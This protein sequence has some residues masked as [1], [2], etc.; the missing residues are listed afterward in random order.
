MERIDGGF[1]I[2]FSFIF[3]ISFTLSINNPNC[4]PLISV[5]K[6]C[7][8]SVFSKLNFSPRSIIEIIFP[9]TLINP[10]IKLGEFGIFVISGFSIISLVLWISIAYSSSAKLKTTNCFSF[11]DDSSLFI[12]VISEFISKDSLEELSLDILSSEFILTDEF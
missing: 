3:V 5:T 12:S 4:S 7:F 8:P 11:P 1:L 2:Y 6:I 10:E 9:L